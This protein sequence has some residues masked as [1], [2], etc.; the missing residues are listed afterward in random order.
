MMDDRTKQA[1][2]EARRRAR[3]GLRIVRRARLQPGAV[4]ATVPARDPVGGRV[5]TDLRSHIRAAVEARHQRVEVGAEE[6]AG[7]WVASVVADGG[8]YFASAVGMSEEAAL[9]AL[10]GKVS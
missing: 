3:R 2:D 6:L 7:R 9:T 4:G 10:L 8:R 5:T 1:L